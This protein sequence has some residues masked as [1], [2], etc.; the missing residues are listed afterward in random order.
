MYGSVETRGVRRTLGL[1][2]H[3]DGQPVVPEKWS[4]SPWEPTPYTRAP[5]T[6]EARRARD[7]PMTY[8]PQAARTWRGAQTGT[9]CWSIGLTTRGNE[10]GRVRSRH[11]RSHKR[12]GAV[13]PVAPAGERASV[14]RGFTLR[15]VASDDVDPTRRA[16]SVSCRQGL[17]TVRD[18]QRGD[19]RVVN[20]PASDARPCD[21]TPEQG[22]K[23]MRPA[24]QPDRRRARARAK[25]ASAISPL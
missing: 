17:D 24:Q 4:Q 14:R 23:R 25:S 15:N 3:Y 19:A 7:T 10:G 13:S 2:A 6:R 8:P 5:S 18:T 21:E 22:G 1:Y 11:R 12:N 9:S 16:G 20:D